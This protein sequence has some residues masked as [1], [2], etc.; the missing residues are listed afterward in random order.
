LSRFLADENFPGS[1]IHLLRVAGHDVAAIIEDMPGVED[2]EV[3]ARAVR[4]R[5][6]V[7]TFDRDYGELI[8]GRRLP[9]PVGVVYFRLDDAPPEEAARMLLFLLALDVVSLEG[10]FTTLEERQLRQRPLP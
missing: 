5:Q 6:I 3:L 2:T 9:T 7:L 8:F 1:S 4:E 10:N